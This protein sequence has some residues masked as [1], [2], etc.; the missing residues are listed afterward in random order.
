VIERSQIVVEFRNVY[1]NDLIYPL[2]RMAKLFTKLSGKKTLS[3]LDVYRIVE[4]GFKVVTKHGTPIPHHQKTTNVS[5]LY[6][7]SE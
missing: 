6:H 7:L 1:G 3:M 4:L 2:C 5:H